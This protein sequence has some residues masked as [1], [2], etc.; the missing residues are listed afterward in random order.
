MLLKESYFDAVGVMVE[1]LLSSLS[2]RYWLEFCE[3]CEFSEVLGGGGEMEL[4]FGAV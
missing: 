3:F 1:R 4:V 2:H